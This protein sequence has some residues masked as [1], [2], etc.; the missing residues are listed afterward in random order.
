M[1]ELLVL[2]L[3][4]FDNASSKK[5]EASEYS[6]LDKSGYKTAFIT[7]YVFL[8]LSQTHQLVI[9]EDDFI[10]KHYTFNIILKIPLNHY[11]SSKLYFIKQL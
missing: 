3:N 7:L 2:Y 1:V 8:E 4:P 6:A 10:I 11:L 5:V 9:L